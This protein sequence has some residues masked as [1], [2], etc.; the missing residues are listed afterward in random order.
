MFWPTL[1]ELERNYIATVLGETRWRRVQATRTSSGSIGARCTAK[2]APTAYSRPHPRVQEP[3]PP[4]PVPPALEETA[5]GYATAHPP[6]SLIHQTVS[7]RIDPSV[8]HSSLSW[9]RV[10]VTSGDLCRHNP[11]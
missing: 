8:A 7:G 3:R 6:L 9:Y 4:S 2:S 11:P 10:F 1:E 5:P